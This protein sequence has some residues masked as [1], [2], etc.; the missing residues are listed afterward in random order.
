MALDAAGEGLPFRVGLVVLVCHEEAVVD[1]VEVGFK[2]CGAVVGGPEPL[3]VCRELRGSDQSVGLVKVLE[4][5]PYGAGGEARHTVP[6][7]LDIYVV[8]GVDKLVF[9]DIVNCFEE[10]EFA[11]GFFMLAFRVSDLSVGGSQCYNRMDARVERYDE[12]YARAEEVSRI[13]RSEDVMA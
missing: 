6:E 10:E 2:V 7:I 4:N 1:A 3:V 13:Q 12:G 5:V 8:D 9:K 11:Y